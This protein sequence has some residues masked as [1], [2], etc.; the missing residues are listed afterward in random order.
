LVSAHLNDF[1]PIVYKCTI[2]DDSLIREVDLGP[3]KHRVDDGLPLRKA[4]FQCMDTLLDA[5]PMLLELD[6]YCKYLKNGINDESP[7]INMQTYQILTRLAATQGARIIQCL[8]EMPTDLMK[9]IKGKMQEAKNN[10]DGERA[11]DILRAAVKALWTMR[12]V[13]DV[14]AARKF[15]AFYS[16]VEK[17]KILIPMIEALKKEHAKHGA[18]QNQTPM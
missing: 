12:N 11:K 13:P 10:K 16:R 14:A 5:C 9:G 6:E 1:L 4:A 17:T 8:E 7:D 3:F 18:A 15:V 2:T